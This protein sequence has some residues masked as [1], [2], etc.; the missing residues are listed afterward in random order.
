MEERTKKK[1]KE[2]ADS[3]PSP[4]SETEH[5]PNRIGAYYSQ[6]ALWPYRI[7]CSVPYRHANEAGFALIF[8]PLINFSPP[9]Q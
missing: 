7:R 2:I 8:V 4:A 9:R 5:Q 3:D 6:Y 1:K